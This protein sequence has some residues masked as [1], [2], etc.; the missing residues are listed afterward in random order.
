LRR[1]EPDRVVEFIL[2]P[3]APA[4]ADSRLMQIV[5]DNL[6]HNAWKY[7]AHHPRARIEFGQE[8]RDGQVSY[9]VKDDGSG[10]DSRSADRLFQPFQRLHSAAEFPGNGIGLATVRRIIQRHGGRVWAEGGIEHGATFYFTLDA[11]RT[12][13]QSA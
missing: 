2:T 7:T 9:F 13:S 4:F 1:R 5:L 8:T 12:G 10:F 11:A 3:L 6:L